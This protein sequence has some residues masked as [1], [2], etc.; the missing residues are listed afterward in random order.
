M[1]HGDFSRQISEFEE[2]LQKVAKEITGG[3]LLERLSPMD[4]WRKCE[5]SVTRLKDLAEGS[6]DS[7]LILKPE[8]AVTIERCCKAFVQ[9]LTT[10]KDILFQKSS[11]PKANSRLAFEQLREAVNEGSDFL[12]LMKE[13]R[14]TPS[15]VIEAI[16]TL[17]ETV[18]SKAKVVTIQTTKDVQPMLERLTKSIAA[19]RE[20]LISLEHAL[21]EVKE[22]LHALEEE[23]TRFGFEEAV[24][25]LKPTKK[26][27]NVQEEAK[28]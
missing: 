14:E 6:R 18:E 5:A 19:L 15:A 8:R 1:I 26:N 13:I 10:F 16:L 7:M 11:D 2:I 28:L 17:R 9:A 12:V 4:L 21:S 22:R 20:S 25:V 3:V 24:S 23:S 27:E